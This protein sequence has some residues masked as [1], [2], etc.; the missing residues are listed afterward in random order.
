M[1]QVTLSASDRLL[2]LQIINEQRCGHVELRKWLK[3]AD[4][5]DFESGVEQFEGVKF[6]D[7]RLRSHP[8]KE[9]ELEDDHY[10]MLRNAIKKH[11]AWPVMMG[12]L[13]DKMLQKFD[14]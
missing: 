5:I 13:I 2:L 1:K 10:D 9:V 6:D 7:E 3:V 4:A 14:L 12:D 8:E 11:N